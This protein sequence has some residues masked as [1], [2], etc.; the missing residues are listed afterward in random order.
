M[1]FS[2]NYSPLLAGLIQSGSMSIDRFKCPD[3]PDLLAEARNLLPVYIHFPLLIGSGQGSPLDGETHQPADFERIAELMEGT[4]TPY[5]NTHFIAPVS[6]YP[7]ISLDSTAS[8]HWRCILDGALRDLEPLIDRF[9][10]EQVLV[11]NII[12][13]P[14]WLDACALPEV[15]SA[16]VE[17]TGC[18]FLFDLSHARLA[19]ANLGIDPREYIRALPV[20][21]MREMHITGIQVLE[22]QLLK[23]VLAI[24]DP[25]GMAANNSGKGIDHVSMVEEDWTELAWALDQIAAGAW[26]T[27]WVASY[28]YGGVGPFWERLSDRETYQEQVPRMAQ[29]VLSASL[30]AASK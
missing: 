21:Y 18:G 9:G 8:G 15:I 19:A 3:W 14:G 24:G 25:Y 27:P 29:M 13:Q 26:S 30:R 10:Q 23:T 2:V 22:G 4:G 11:E 7:G 5:V 20:G 17:E 1:L 12:N 28:E 16:L 6:Y